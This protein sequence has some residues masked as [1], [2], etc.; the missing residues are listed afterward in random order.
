MYHVLVL[1]KV[2]Y[3]YPGGLY[4]YMY[5]VFLLVYYFFLEDMTGTWSLCIVYAL[6]GIIRAVNVYHMKHFC[7]FFPW[8]LAEIIEDLM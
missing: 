8:K 5:S 3:F 6:K 1:L 4:N 2:E 7:S